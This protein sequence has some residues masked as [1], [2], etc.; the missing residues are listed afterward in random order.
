MK[1]ALATILKYVI[2]LGLGI[3]IGWYM[4]YKVQKDGN[5]DKLLNSIYQSVNPPWYLLTI[6]FVGFL[7]HYIRAIRWRYLLETIDLRPTLTNTMFAVMIGYVTNLILPRAGEVAKCT[8]LAKYEDM[9]AHKMVGTIVAERAF[10]MV[11]LLGIALVTFLLEMGRISSYISKFIVPY[12]KGLETVLFISLGVFAIVLFAIMVWYRKNKD[13]K[14]GLLVKEMTHGILSIVHMKKKW[15]FV[16]LTVLMWLMYTLQIYLG[17]KSVGAN[18][19]LV[20]SMV[21]LV[22][23]SVALIFV[24]GGIGLYPW[25]VSQMLQGPYQIDQITSDAFGWIAWA[26]QT[27]VVIIL[28]VFSLL[29]IH[30]YNKNRN[31]KVAVDTE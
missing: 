18:L 14:I 1:K 17:L 23:G 26:V 19:S 29:F 30:S 6:C 20:S 27:G 22:W 16:I 13:S 21:V 5:L 8:V 7:S 9:P 15:E 10:D 3:G 4:L 31:A 28:G 25:L 2:F 11:C 12:L 24:P